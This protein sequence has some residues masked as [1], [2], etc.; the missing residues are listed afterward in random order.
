[1]RTLR[2]LVKL[3]FNVKFIKMG[4]RPVCR[5]DV[6]NT[7]VSYWHLLNSGVVAFFFA[8]ANTARSDV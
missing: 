8:S 1:M 4:G 5:D 2:F 7:L 6:N 3:N